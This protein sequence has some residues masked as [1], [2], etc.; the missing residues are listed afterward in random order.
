M[1]P[2]VHYDHDVTLKIKI[3]VT[4]QSG[5][6]TISGVTE[7]ILSQR[8]VD[9]VIRLREG[10]A[11]IL[12]GIQDK[13]EMVSLERHPRP[14]L[15]PDPQVPLRLQGSHHHRRRTRLPRRPPRRPHAEP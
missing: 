3:E 1:T 8:V 2:T 5:S 9:Q 4:S 15:D 13:Q 10:E 7:P 11:S 6:V 12:G 14:E